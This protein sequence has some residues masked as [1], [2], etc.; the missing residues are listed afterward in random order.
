MLSRQLRCDL[1]SMFYHCVRLQISV[2][3]NSKVKYKST[4][5]LRKHG[6]M[7]EKSVCFA[8]LEHIHHINV[9]FFGYF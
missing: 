2:N 7:N 4:L 3:L 1:P 9:G 6:E 5:L 8:N